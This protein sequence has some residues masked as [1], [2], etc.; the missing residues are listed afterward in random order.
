MGLLAR[1]SGRQGGL[2][3]RV[4][5]RTT[6]GCRQGKVAHSGCQAG[7]VGGRP[8]SEGRQG[9]LNFVEGQ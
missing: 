5:L 7:Q 3:G 4:R 2:E 6:W 9:G 1:W 8:W